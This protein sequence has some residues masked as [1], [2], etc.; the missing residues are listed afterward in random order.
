MNPTNPMNSINPEHT[1][2]DYATVNSRLILNKNTHHQE[3]ETAD[4]RRLTQIDMNKRHTPP[5]E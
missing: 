5:K 3:N 2:K 1:T 4:A